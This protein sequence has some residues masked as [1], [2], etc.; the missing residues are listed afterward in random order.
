VSIAESIVE[1]N[2]T[3]VVSTGY[4]RVSGSEVSDN[5]GDGIQ[6]G[7]TL[8]TF[9]VHIE[10]NGGSG[11]VIDSVEGDTK[12]FLSEVSHNGLDGVR[13]EGL[14]TSRLHT[15][16]AFVR[17]NGRDGISARRLDVHRTRADHN[18]RHGIYQAPGDG[19]CVLTI[20]H[21]SMVGNGTDPDCGVSMTCA[22][23]AS[24]TAPANINETPCDTSYD[25][26]SGFPGT[27]WGICED[28]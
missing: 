7:P 5:I 8:L 19:D 17:F 23:L 24:C 2:G 20:N 14:Q 15:R 9:R 10:R 22:D 13:V 28:D 16:L 3:G 25:T 11:I 4:L 12:V 21:Y 26:N 27:S 1:L 18:G 6:A